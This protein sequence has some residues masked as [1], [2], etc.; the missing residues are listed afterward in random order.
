M[1]PG[2]IAILI[3]L[4]TLVLMVLQ[5]FPLAVTALLSAFLMAVFGMITP[6]EILAQFGTGTFFCV[7]GMM[8]VG[9]AI[10]KTGLAKKIGR[11]VLRGRNNERLL[12]VILIVTVT[13][14]SGFL[15]NTTCA[16]MFLPLA[17]S[18]ARDSNGRISRK[19]TFLCIGYAATLGG[20]ATLVGSPSQHLLA[21]DLLQEAGYPL[22]SFFFG[23]PA[24]LLMMAVMALY[25]STIGYRLEKKV[26]DF[27]DPRDQELPVPVEEGQERFSL[28][29][30]LSG[31]IL[32]GTV[33]CIAAG[34]LGSGEG[35]LLGAVLVVASRCLSLEDAIDCIN[36]P[37]CLML[38]GLFAM[39]KGFNNSGAG[40]LIVDSAIRVM[41]SDISPMLIFALCILLASFLTNI[42]D[43]I[44]TQALLGPTFL[45]LAVYYHINPV[46]MLYAL[47]FACNLAYLTPVGT[48]AV[49]MT[50]SGGYRFR[51]YFKVGFPL[52]ILGYLFILFIIPLLYGFSF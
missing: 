29:M 21:Q 35:A 22:M 49:A 23:M 18:V 17:A 4:F 13:L 19:N 48:P 41:G 39:T 44:A 30:I 27:E 5:V 31:L 50:L 32:I 36:W 51:D 2:I 42:L 43:N 25:F 37:I 52:W 46:T 3:V 16:A 10:F 34:L 14:M 33:S 28:R 9:G 7:P 38:G 40:E 1:S 20:C 11:L 6:K 15:S 47:V 12:I 24:T 8:V 45:S 26:F